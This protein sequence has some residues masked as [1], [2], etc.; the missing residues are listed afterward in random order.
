MKKNALTILFTLFALTASV[1]R[2]QSFDGGVTAG[3]VASQI[4]GDGYGGFHQLGGTGGFFV[5]IPT[6]GPSSWQLELRY[7]LLGAHS[8][9]KEVELGMLPMEIRLHYAEL[10]VLF[11]YDL[12]GLSFNGTP[13]NFV[14]LEAGIS[15]TFL[16]SGKQSADFED[17]FENTSWLA[18][19]A[20]GHL[21]IQL[22]LN[23]HW[24]AN[25]RYLHSLTP[26]RWNPNVPSLF[27]GH[28]Y[29]VALTA[30]LTYTF[31]HAGK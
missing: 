11:R 17:L 10:P 23:D 31:I 3:L 24:G 14:T 19:T 29:H 12:S 30:S 1:C 9:V 15:P 5:R 20:L 16:I 22:D 4:D 26:C 8:D 18:F 28:L 6:E 2:A 13:M 7:T 21:G 25:L 27:Y